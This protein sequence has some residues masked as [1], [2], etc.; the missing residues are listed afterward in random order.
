MERGA[1]LDDVVIHRLQPRARAE[2]GQ[3][4]CRLAV[5]DDLHQATAWQDL[6]IVHRDLLDIFGR[7]RQEHGAVGHAE[8][9]AVPDSYRRIG[10]VHVQEQMV[11]RRAKHAHALADRRQ[12]F[13][14]DVLAADIGDGAQPVAIVREIGLVAKSIV[15]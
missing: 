12:P 15:A 7:H 4:R 13:D 11:A 14:H 6:D 9:D 10:V 5:G 8:G 2:L 1:R 3:H